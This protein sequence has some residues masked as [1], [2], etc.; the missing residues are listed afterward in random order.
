[1]QLTCIYLGVAMQRL[2]L[3]FL[4]CGTILISST[5][6]WA[7]G[8]DGALPQV[9]IVLFY[10]PTC[11][12]CH[13]VINEDLPPLQEQ[14]GEQ[15]Q[16]LG[17]DVSQAAGGQLYQDAISALNIAENRLGVPTLIIGETIL[18]GSLEIPQQLPL[19]I[20]TG[21]ESG[22]VGWP[23]IPSLYVIVPNLPPSADPN[24]SEVVDPSALSPTTSPPPA[25]TSEPASARCA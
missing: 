23:E 15:L 1:M 4:I 9:Q 21:L 14:Y 5:P 10:S 19:L 11:P 12:H 13:K 22:G 8:A 6:A 7:Q 25:A 2:F 24:T 18:V 17:V 3:T 16:I 20:A